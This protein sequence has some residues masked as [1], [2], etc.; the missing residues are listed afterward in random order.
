[1]SRKD[2]AYRK[3]RER[4][5]AEARRRE[6][7]AKR[8][9]PKSSGGKEVL[10]ALKDLFKEDAGEALNLAISSG[11]SEGQIAERLKVDAGT[12]QR[13]LG[14]VE[15]LPPSVR[16][17]LRGHPQ[18]LRKTAVLEEILRGVGRGL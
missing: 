9:D 16:E 12:V 2:D 15:K 1:M 8:Q 3:A 4:R 6:E 10:R 11:L 13:L 14:L 18:M 5:K 17:L 7:E